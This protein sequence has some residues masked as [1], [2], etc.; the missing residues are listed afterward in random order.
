M[1]MVALRKKDAQQGAA[2]GLRA[3]AIRIPSDMTVRGGGR[4]RTALYC[5]QAWYLN[6]DRRGTSL[7]RKAVGDEFLVKIRRR[8]T[9]A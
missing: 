6:A 1:R 3:T 4:C 2:S 8:F 5:E 9:A 7:N